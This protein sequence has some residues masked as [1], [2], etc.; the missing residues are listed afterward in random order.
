M[1]LGY[2]YK[3]EKNENKVN[4]SDDEAD[5][6]ISKDEKSNQVDVCV[7]SFSFEVADEIAGSLIMKIK[8]GENLQ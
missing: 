5:I 6:V 4:F 2:A 8:E 3:V 7:S 1:K